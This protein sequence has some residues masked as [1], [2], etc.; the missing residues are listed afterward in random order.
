MHQ[1]TCELELTGR[2]LL[3]TL[4]HG[5]RALRQRRD[6]PNFVR[7][8]LSQL[9][10]GMHLLDLSENLLAQLTLGACRALQFAGPESHTLNRDENQIIMALIAA[11]LGLKSDVRLLLADLQHSGGLRRTQRAC[12]ALAT[13]LDHHDL[14]LSRIMS[15]KPR[16]F[17]PEKDH[18]S[19]T[20]SSR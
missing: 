9:P 2:L 7:H 19:R 1:N 8:T 11:Q 4:R 15:S 14:P 3:W 13:I 16:I 17:V 18:E 20:T 6:L 12:F 10:A 5:S